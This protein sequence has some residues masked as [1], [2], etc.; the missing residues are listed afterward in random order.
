MLDIMFH[1]ARFT[2]TKR[3]LPTHLKIDNAK[4]DV[5]AA[6]GGICGRVILGEGREKRPRPCLFTAATRN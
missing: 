1:I 6:A 5:G 3:Y 2:V 4:T